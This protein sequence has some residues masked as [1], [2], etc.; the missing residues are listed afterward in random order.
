MH[1]PL[2]TPRPIVR[3]RSRPRRDKQRLSTSGN[4]RVDAATLASALQLQEE[5]REFIYSS[6]AL[7]MKL[8][9]L[10]LGVVSLV[11]LGFA[12]HQ[13][14]GRHAELTTVLDVESVKLVS[15]Q[16]RFDRLFTIGGDRRLM[17]EQDQWIAPN[18]VRVIWR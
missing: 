10:S 11:K 1:S 18:R 2:V 8:G 12:S 9:F 15:L 3:S 4:Q 16:K 13:R 5:Q 14:V 6:M 7:V 17:D